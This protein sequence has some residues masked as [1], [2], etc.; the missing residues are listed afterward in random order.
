MT[1]EAEQINVADKTTFDF[2]I[3]PPPPHHSKKKHVLSRFF[4][5]TIQKEGY[6]KQKK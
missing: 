2:S 3:Y 4:L 5:K 1:A 6:T